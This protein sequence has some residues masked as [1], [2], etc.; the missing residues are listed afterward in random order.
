MAAAF[1]QKAFGRQ[2]LD[3]NPKVN[4]TDR[5]ARA[6]PR[7]P[8]K[9]DHYGRPV[10][11]FFEPRGNNA[12]NT[13]MPAFACGPNQGLIKAAFGGLLKGGALDLVFYGAALDIQ[14]IKPIS[15]I[16]ALLR[17]CFYALL[18]AAGNCAVQA[19]MGPI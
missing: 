14:L 17:W 19:M 4:P 10:A 5:S 13:G 16:C 2:P 12:N 8:I 11:G 6:L 18:S 9:T 1:L 3:L 15:A 7:I